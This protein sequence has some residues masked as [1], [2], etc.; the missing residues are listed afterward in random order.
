MK[1]DCITLLIQRSMHQP[2]SYLNRVVL[3]LCIGFVTKARPIINCFYLF[4]PLWKMGDGAGNSKSVILAWPFPWPAPSRSP[5]RLTS[6]GQKTQL[7]GNSRSLGTLRHGW[8]QRP[9][10]RAKDAPSI[11][12]TKEIKGI[13]R[14]SVSGTRGRDII[15]ISQLI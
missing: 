1:L 3:G 12:I 4:L 2:G 5:P 13:F 14:S 10:I 7:P 6:L 9:S 15:F 8:N 11:L